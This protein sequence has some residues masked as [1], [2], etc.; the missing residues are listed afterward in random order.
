[1]IRTNLST[2]PFYNERAVHVV[3]VVAAVVVIAL[4]LFNIVRI[5]SLS[6]QNTELTTRINSDRAE[7]QRLNAEAEKIRRGIDADELKTT[8]GA[9]AEANRL[10][11]QRT[12]SWSAF[13]DRIE[14]TLPADVMLTAVQPSFDQTTPIVVMTVLG[15]RTEDV[16]DFIM[17]LEGTGAF[18]QVLPSQSESTDEGL[19]RVQLRAVYT[20]AATQT[21]AGQ[22]AA[23]PT[24]PGGASTPSAV[25]ASAP[26]P[27]GKGGEQ[28][29][30]PAGRGK[31]A[32][33]GA[34]R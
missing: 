27:G 7:V 30:A 22:A 4:T 29:A 24:A 32:G 5:V 8:V 6:R 13:F 10:I 20:G 34:A 31:P 3:L 9:A 28:D 25:P 17:K 2:R 1:M 14:A 11:E 23:E 18:T 26:A 33:E 19:H 12:F 16:D 15:R 21:G